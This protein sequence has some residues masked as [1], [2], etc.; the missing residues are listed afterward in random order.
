MR[1]TL[2][3]ALVMSLA[4]ASALSSADWLSAQ[5]PLADLSKANTSAFVRSNL[6]VNSVNTT[7]TPAIANVTFQGHYASIGQEFS[8]SKDWS[9][10]N[11]VHLYMKNRNSFPVQFGLAVQMY[12]DPSNYSGAFTGQF[13]L[14]PGMST[15]FLFYLNAD[16]PLPYGLKFLNPALTAPSTD[17]YQGGRR[18]LKTVYRWRISYQGTTAA[19]VDI[20]DMR[21]LR[22]SLNFTGLS[23]QFGQYTDRVWPG[24]VYSRTDFAPELSAENSDL[25]SHPGTGET[26]GTTKVAN[27]A[28]QLGRWAV[29]TLSNG[30]KMLQHPNGKLFWSLGLSGV[31]DS[32]PTKVQDRSSYFKSL[33]STSGEFASCYSTMGTPDGA[34]LCYSFRKQNLMMKYGDNYMTPWSAMVKKRLASWGV[35]TLGIDCKE[36]LYMNSTV[37]FTVRLSTDSFGTRFRAPVMTWGSLPDPYDANFANW[38]INEFAQDLPK[39]VANANLMGVF[40]DNE[41]S[42][43]G[44][45]SNALRYNLALGALTA[46]ATQPA[47][48]GFVTKL[49]TKYGTI[50][51]LNSAW[52]TSFSSFNSILY[53]TSWRPTTYTTGMI[54]DFQ[55]F[56]GTFAYKYFWAVNHALKYDGLKSFY[57]G[58]RFSAYTTEVVNSAAPNCDVLSFNFYRY[59]TDMPWSYLASL[60]KPVLISE[61][62]YALKAWGTFG[63]P[64]MAG[65]PAGRAERLQQFLDTV[66]T[67]K[68][69]IG[70]HYYCYADQPITGRYTD[71]ENGGFGIVDNV[72]NPYSSSVTAL[73]QFTSDMYTTRASGS[74]TSGGSG[75]GSGGSTG[76]VP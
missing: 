9:G 21:L 49:Q 16:N 71:Y 36:A 25:A 45:D 4:A 17:V 18:N 24:K 5:T 8:T 56:C 65:D 33:P 58:C 38:C 12:S 10:Y 42:W 39:Y 48:I 3:L 27:P 54:V 30:Q 62:G 72:D 41:M 31:N 68:N 60:S 22:Q 15:H 40:V 46:P 73:R 6:T 57:L 26:L 37:P 23:D 34:K 7:V 64:A 66:I 28:P 61:F 70:A 50:G 63:G 69:I 76:A 20:S 67:Q 44:M 52:G 59:I 35:N 14:S 19:N 51:A 43:G 32:S 13:Y 55:S 11:I 1:V 74:T 29:I 53:N 47:K 2:T 75:G